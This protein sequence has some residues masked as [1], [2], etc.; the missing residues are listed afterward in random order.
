MFWSEDPPARHSQLPVSE[1]EWMTHVVTYPSSISDLLNDLSRSGLCT[2]MSQDSCHRSLDQ[3]FRPSS[4]RW[5]NAAMGSPTECWTHSSTAFPSDGAEYS[6]LAAVLE[7]GDIPQRY[8]L[9][10][11]AASGVLRRSLLR[12]KELPPLLL[13]ALMAQAGLTAD[14]M[15][16]LAQ[17]PESGTKEQEA[18]QEMNITTSSQ[19]DLESEEEPTE[20]SPEE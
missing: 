6:S 12:G 10:A 4:Q 3:T 8:F 14:Q 2:K 5:L 9:T 18:Q 16:S 20:D 19:Q 15:A 1:K 13:Q 11:R 17:S 7:T